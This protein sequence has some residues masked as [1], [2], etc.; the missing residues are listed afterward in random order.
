MKRLLLFTIIFAIVGCG[1]HVVVVPEDV[2]KHNNPDWT[3]KTEPAKTG[4]NKK[5]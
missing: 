5:M 2:P 4:V 1:R 3:I